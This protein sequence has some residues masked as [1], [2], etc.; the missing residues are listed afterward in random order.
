[1]PIVEK[2]GQGPVPKWTG[3]EKRKSLS[4]TG[5][6]VTGRKVQHFATKTRRDFKS[7]MSAAASTVGPG[8]K[9]RR[10]R[11]LSGNSLHI[12]HNKNDC[13]HNSHD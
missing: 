6:K 4:F 8:A 13:P 9:W 5:V 7:L 10:L 1:V 11:M 2:D 3:A 12:S